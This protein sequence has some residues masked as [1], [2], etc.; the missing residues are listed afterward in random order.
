MSFHFLFVYNFKFLFYFSE[1]GH[2]SRSKIEFF[3]NW[4]PNP[5]VMTRLVT[6]ATRP[7]FSNLFE[8]NLIL[9][10]IFNIFARF[11]DQRTL[12]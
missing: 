9:D 1:T 12:R 7:Y 2:W 4:S 5:L 11:L 8:L 10:F 3:K 6:K